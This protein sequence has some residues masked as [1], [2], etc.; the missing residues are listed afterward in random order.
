MI[1]TFVAR[2][3]AESGFPERAEAEILRAH[4]VAERSDSPPDRF[5]AWVNS[6]YACLSLRDTRSIARCIERAYAIDL[7]NRPPMW[8]A[9]AGVYGA[10]ARALQ[11]EPEPAIAELRQA[12]DGWA[13]LGNRAGFGT[14]LGLLANAELLAGR[15]AEGLATIERALVVAPEDRIHMPELLRLQAE[16][17]AASGA[18]LTAVESDLREAIVLAREMGAKLQELRATTSLARQLARHGR[19]AE[20]RE[21]L[22]PLYAS[23]TEGFGARDLV[24]AKGLLDELG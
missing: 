8:V 4:E 16:L 18:S 1:H 17:R 15:P 22:A 6:C 10:W 14:Y 24:E 19:T 2:A 20:G 13:A 3:L 11:G 7:A 12:I 21:L 5:G 23:F 9:I